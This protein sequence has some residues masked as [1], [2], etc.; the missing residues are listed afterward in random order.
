MPKE[1]DDPDSRRIRHGLIFLVMGT[2]LV[3]WAWG[4]WLYRGWKPDALPSAAPADAVDS[5]VN[6]AGNGG[7]I[8]ILLVVALLILVLVVLG[9]CILVRIR[10]R[11]RKT[12]GPQYRSPSEW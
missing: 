10:R 12:I 7:S 6:Q 11:M 5:L 8:S 2:L 1:V 9:T 4:S 3:V